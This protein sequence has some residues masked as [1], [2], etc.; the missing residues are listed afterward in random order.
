MLF[1]SDPYSSLNPRRRI[2]QS[3]IEGP[4]RH[5]ASDSDARRRVAELL[6][7]VG[8]QPSSMNRFPHEF[9]GGQRQRIC[10]ARAL[11]LEPDIIVAD[12]AVSALDVTVQAQVLELFLSLQ[13]DLGFAMLFITHD[14]RVASNICNRIAVMNR[15]QVVETGDTQSIFQHSQHE[16]TRRLIAALPSDLSDK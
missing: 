8:L 11:A 7:H 5:G 6:E 15:G 4:V 9:S 13:R 2:G 14:L 1:R 10:I 16:Y 3:L 12:E